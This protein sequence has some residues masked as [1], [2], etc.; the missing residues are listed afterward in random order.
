MLKDCVSVIVPVYNVEAYLKD[1]LES[2]INQTYRE[3]EIILI[4]DGSTDCS[5]RICDEYALK[6]KRIVVAHQ[7]NCGASVARNLALDMV[8][9]EFFTFVDGDDTIDLRYIE[10]MVDKIKSFDVDLVRMSWYRGDRKYTYRVPFNNAGEYLVDTS[11][12]DDLLWF[13]NIWG[14]FRTESLNMVR[15]DVSMK[16]AEDNL[17]LFEFFLMSNR[18]KMLL[19]DKPLYRYRIVGSSA[20][21]VDALVCLKRSKYFVEKILNIKSDFDALPLVDKYIYKDYLFCLYFFTDEKI[22]EKDGI[23]INEIRKKIVYLRKRGCREKKFA[24]IVS[25]FIYRHHLHFLMCVYR[26]FFSSN[27]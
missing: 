15:F 2:I 27:R 24:N 7:K 3:L 17:F 4:D 18:K 5:G 9:G 23:T 6:D 14:L 22:K 19:M 10:L 1:S 8:K 25:S 21:H 13:A 11:N 16:Y 20:T 26:R 12:V